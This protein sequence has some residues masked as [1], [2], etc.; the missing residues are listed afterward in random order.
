M[1]CICRAAVFASLARTADCAANLRPVD[2]LITHPSEVKFTT[3]TTRS[4]THERLKERLLIERNRTKRAHFRGSPLFQATYD[5]KTEEKKTM[6]S[7][8]LVSVGCGRLAE[9][10]G[11]DTMSVTIVI[12]TKYFSINIEKQELN[13]L[14]SA[15]RVT[16]RRIAAY[17]PVEYTQKAYINE[18]SVCGTEQ[19]TV[20]K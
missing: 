2:W 1:N 10:K 12:R 9:G 6:N 17:P 5:I 7:T 3:D 15:Y 16:P 18:C 19:T 11:N 13:Y 4:K 14:C 8:D 20:N